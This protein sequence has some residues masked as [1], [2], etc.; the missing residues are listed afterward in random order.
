MNTTAVLILNSLPSVAD[1][2]AEIASIAAN[3]SRMLSG[4]IWV[5]RRASDSWV[6]GGS[7]PHRSAAHAAVDLRE[8]AFAAWAKHAAANPYFL[9]D[10]AAGMYSW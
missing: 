4:A 5:E 6:V 10:A 1:L 9:E 8:R 2:T 7:E 3:S